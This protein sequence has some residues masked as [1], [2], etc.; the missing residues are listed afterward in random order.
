MKY[1]IKLLQEEM[2]TLMK[3]NGEEVEA[4]DDEENEIKITISYSKK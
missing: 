2:E 4:I 1:K 3:G